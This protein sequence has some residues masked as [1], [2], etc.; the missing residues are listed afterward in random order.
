MRPFV[1]AIFAFNVMLLAWTAS[2]PVS[3]PLKKA[4]R[5]VQNDDVDTI[6]LLSE[7]EKDT[8]LQTPGRYCFSLG[9]IQDA[10]LFELTRLEINQKAVSVNGRRSEALVEMGYMVYLP[11]YDDPLQAQDMLTELQQAGVR[12]VAIVS[13]ADDQFVI[14]LGF[15]A[16]VARADIR[17]GEIERLGYQARSMIRRVRRQQYWL[18]YELSSGV[19]LTGLSVFGSKQPIYRRTIPCAAAP[20][21]EPA[22]TRLPLVTVDGDKQPNGPTQVNPGS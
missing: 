9:P 22:Q 2:Q 1:L 12:D 11:P 10:D 14:S 19:E 7:L 6:H 8:D 15:Y 13:G 3:P 21:A 20:P 16:R 18:D 5:H 4:V 17:A